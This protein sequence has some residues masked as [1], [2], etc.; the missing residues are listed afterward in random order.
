MKSAWNGI[1]RQYELSQY[2]FASPILL[3]YFWY[4]I[5]SCV[6]FVEK[7]KVLVRVKIS[8]ARRDQELTYYWHYKYF[9]NFERVPRLA[10]SLI[11]IRELLR[12]YNGESRTIEE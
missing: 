10:T 8:D 6:L 2:T 9:L 7:I 1:F 3:Q 4:S 12:A 11:Q 5:P